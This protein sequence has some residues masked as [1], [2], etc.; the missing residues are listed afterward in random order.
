ML[1]MAH[2]TLESISADRMVSHFVSCAFQVVIYS[3]P[4]PY[5]FGPL[6]FPGLVRTED[7]E[8]FAADLPQASEGDL[9]VC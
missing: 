9:Y 2:H 1:P 3:V 8:E 5:F 4:S 6:N 7:P